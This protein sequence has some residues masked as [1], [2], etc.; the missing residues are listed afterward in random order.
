LQSGCKSGICG[1]SAS[2]FG[3]SVSMPIAVLGLSGH[4]NGYRATVA[5]ICNILGHTVENN[6]L[7]LETRYL[8]IYCALNLSLYILS[9]Y[10]G[11]RS[12]GLLGCPTLCVAYSFPN[13]EQSRATPVLPLRASDLVGQK[14]SSRSRSVVRAI[15]LAQIACTRTGVPKRYINTTQNTKTRKGVDR[16]KSDPTTAPSEVTPCQL[17]VTRSSVLAVP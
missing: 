5:V 11:L 12:L 7:Y 4:C 15:L 1:H 16:D 2:V 9:L 10:R 6:K 8:A 13:R 17:A 14:S 3:N